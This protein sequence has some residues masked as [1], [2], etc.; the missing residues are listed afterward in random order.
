MEDLTRMQLETRMMLE[1]ARLRTH[2]AV[3]LYA[4][5]IKTKQDLA[6]EEQDALWEKVQ[7]AIQDS[8][9]KKLLRR[10][11]LYPDLEEIGE[12]IESSKN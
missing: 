9:V 11:S 12:W 1:V 2:D 10:A 4:E 5:G 3:I 6:N 8:R 7:E